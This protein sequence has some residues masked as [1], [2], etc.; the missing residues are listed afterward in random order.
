MALTSVPN[1]IRTTIYD[2]L[3]AS[4]LPS[5]SVNFWGCDQL[6]TEGNNKGAAPLVLQIQH[7]G[8]IRSM[9]LQRD[10]LVLAEAYLN[11]FFDIIN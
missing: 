2:L 4:G 9:F 3:S 10:P 7:P 5:C 8:V 1:A 11:G 6:Q